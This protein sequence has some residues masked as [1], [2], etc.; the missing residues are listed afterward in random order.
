MCLQIVVINALP[1]GLAC[2][3]SI[4]THRGKVLKFLTQ[5]VEQYYYFSSEGNVW[6]ECKFEH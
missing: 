1:G 6:T 5:D 2:R 4:H 3:E